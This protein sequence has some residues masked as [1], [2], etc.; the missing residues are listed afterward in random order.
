MWMTAGALRELQAERADLEGNEGDLDQF[1]Q[2]RLIELRELIAGADTTPKP[3]DGLVEPGMRVSVT[4]A[5]GSSEDFLLTNRAVADVQT[6]SM[7]SP[8]G[9]ALNGHHVGDEVSFVTPTGARQTV[10]I[11]AATPHG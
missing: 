8:I 1:E 5:D 4:F 3:D 11:T 2:A 7:D 9:E 10:T 6:V